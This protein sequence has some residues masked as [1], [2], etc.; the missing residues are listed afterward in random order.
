MEM[1][2]LWFTALFLLIST[3]YCLGQQVYE[4]RP[5]MDL[6]NSF[7]FQQGESRSMLG[8]KNIEG[9]PYL[10]ESFI[11]GELFTTSKT[12]YENIPLRYNI[13]SDQIEIRSDGGQVMGLTVPEVVEKLEFGEYMMEY[14]PFMNGNKVSRGFF[15]VMEKGNATLY[16]RLQVDFEAA[17][18][19]GAYQDPQPP[20]FVRKSDE[21]YI[22]VGKEAAKPVFRKRDIEAVFPDHI[23]EVADF[24]KKNRVRPNKPERLSALV[25]Y[26][27]GLLQ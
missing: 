21:Y 7:K 16:S 27:N 23:K 1:I 18:P 8:E 26:Y 10:N 17:K 25:K 5:M 20:K 14:V 4:V 19:A 3:M 24:I 22:R 6:I 15:M 9:S 11:E 13:F 2:R 12:H